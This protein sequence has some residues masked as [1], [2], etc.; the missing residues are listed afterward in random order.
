M[1]C[2]FAEVK[3]KLPPEKF[4]GKPGSLLLLI[5]APW[6]LLSGRD[7]GM[8]LFVFACE[9]FFWISFFQ[10]VGGSSLLFPGLM[11]NLC[12][13][14]RFLEFCYPY[15][16]GVMIQF[17]LLSKNP[18]SIVIQFRLCN[19]KLQ[20]M[21]SVLSWILS[22]WLFTLYQC[23]SPWKHQLGEYFLL[24]TSILSKE[25]FG[26]WV[27]NI[28]C[29]C[30]EGPWP[31]NPRYAHVAHLVHLE[32]CRP[33]CWRVVEEWDVSQEVEFGTVMW[34]TFKHP[35]EEKARRA[36]SFFAVFFCSL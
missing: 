10:L 13:G 16:L 23:K 1:R 14:F 3:P 31:I 28:L 22:K 15:A 4:E 25:L 7:G 20:S 19:F 24:F 5:M 17:D 11:L 29:V 18:R 26:A 8:V 30:F 36:S 12:P 21:S 27:Q 35:T 2:S 33:P 6:Y 34:S 9:T 32:L